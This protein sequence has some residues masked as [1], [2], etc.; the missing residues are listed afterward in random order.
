MGPPSAPYLRYPR[1]PGDSDTVASFTGTIL[2]ALYGRDR[3][4]SE[5]LNGVKLGAEMT[6]TLQR[7]FRAD[8]GD[9]ARM[10]VSLV[11]TI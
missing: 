7:L 4:M 10:L 2:G 6:L 11:S 3:L 9:R 5:S 8:V 1:E